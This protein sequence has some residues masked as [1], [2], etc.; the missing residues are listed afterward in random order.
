MDHSVSMVGSGRATAEAIVES[1]NGES[2]TDY[3]DSTTAAGDFSFV[4]GFSYQST[5][6]SSGSAGSPFDRIFR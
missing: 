2:Q 1:N 3:D 4:K 5:T 6:G